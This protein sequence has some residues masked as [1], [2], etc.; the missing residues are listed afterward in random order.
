LRFPALSA[1]KRMM[2]WSGIPCG[3]VVAPRNTMGPEDEARLIEALAAS[4]FKDAAFAKP[5]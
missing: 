5:R 1:V 2:T 4:T 3:D